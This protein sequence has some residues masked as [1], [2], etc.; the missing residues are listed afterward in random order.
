MPIYT[1]VKT[2]RASSGTGHVCVSWMYDDKYCY[3]SKEKEVPTILWSS[4]TKNTAGNETGLGIKFAAC[5]RRRVESQLV[6]LKG[7]T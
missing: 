3:L 5:L 4:E 2:G 6:R 1:R 7:F